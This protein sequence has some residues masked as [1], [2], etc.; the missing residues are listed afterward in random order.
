M[1]FL[2]LF[3]DM[4]MTE[5]EAQNTLYLPDTL[6][7]YQ[8]SLISLTRNKNTA[9]P[10]KHSNHP[11]LGNDFDREAFTPPSLFSICFIFK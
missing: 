8:P 7:S 2:S 6:C 10:R 4:E 11:L 1:I 5:G 3:F 9:H